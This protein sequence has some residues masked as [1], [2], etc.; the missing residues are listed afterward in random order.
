MQKNCFFLSHERILSDLGGY[1]PY[2]HLVKR[3]TSESIDFMRIYPNI[4]VSVVED[5]NL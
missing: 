1:S 3:K 2:Y 5:E 4:S